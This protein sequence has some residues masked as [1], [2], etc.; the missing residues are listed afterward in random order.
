MRIDKFLWCVRYFKT[1]TQATSACK[2]GH[3][4][5]YQVAKPSRLV[6]PTKTYCKNSTNQLSINHFG[7]PKNR[8]GAKLIDIYGLTPHQN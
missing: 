2:K 6:Y 5:V 7:I 8:L 4:K 3:V 1:R